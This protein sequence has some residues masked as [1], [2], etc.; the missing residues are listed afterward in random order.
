MPSGMRVET[1]AVAR[2]LTPT[3]TEADDVGAIVPRGVAN[4]VLLRVARLAPPAGVFV[5][6]LSVLGDGGAPSGPELREETLEGL[7]SGHGYLQSRIASELHLK[8]TPALEFLYDE[9]T[10]RAMRVEDL[11]RRS[12]PE[13]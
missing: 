2:G 6:A 3:P 10:D 4:A 1:E 7:R 5:R 11:L 12:G 8:R 9:T 13:A